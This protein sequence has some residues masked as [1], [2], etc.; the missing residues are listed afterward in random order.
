MILSFHASKFLLKTEHFK[1]F[2]VVTL[3]I[4]FFTFLRVCFCYLLYA[5]AACFLVTFIKYF[6]KVSHLIMWGLWRQCY[7]ACVC[8]VFYAA[9]LLT[10]KSQKKEEERKKEKRDRRRVRVRERKGRRERKRE[11]GRERAKKYKE[12]KLKIESQSQNL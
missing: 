11:A 8:L 4:I 1:Y 10:A 12:V 5:T 6:C 2:N 7:I 3:E 9:I